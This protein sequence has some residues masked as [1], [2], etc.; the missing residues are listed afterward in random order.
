MR[1]FLVTP[2]HSETSIYCHTRSNLGISPMLEILQGCKLDHEVAIKC[3]RNRPT[4]RLRNQ[5]TRH[6]GCATN[7]PT[8]RH[9]IFFLV[10]GRQMSYHVA[11]LSLMVPIDPCHILALILLQQLSVG[12]KL[13]ILKMG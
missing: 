6:I 12:Q 2:H 8:R 4:H 1:A 7:P 11:R 13:R 5:P 10:R 9:H 3:T